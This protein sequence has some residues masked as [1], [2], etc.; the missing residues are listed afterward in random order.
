MLK[1][2][3]EGVAVPGKGRSM[4]DS[5]RGVSAAFFVNL[6]SLPQCSDYLW[7]A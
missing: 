1:V 7:G 6:V 5:V 2:L 4:V 3:D